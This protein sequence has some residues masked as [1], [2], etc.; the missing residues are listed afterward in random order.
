M[1]KKSLSQKFLVCQGQRAMLIGA[2]QIPDNCLAEGQIMVVK[3]V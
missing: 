2:K 3:S 1:S